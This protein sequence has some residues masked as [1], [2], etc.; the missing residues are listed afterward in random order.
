M[1]AGL[2]GVVV[3]GDVFCDII[4]RGVARLPDWGEEVFGAEP[5]M[6]PGGVANV[7]VGLA[8]LGV[9]THLLA[10]TRAEDTIG[11]VLVTELGRQPGLRVTWLRSA[12]ST[13][14]TVAL[15]HGGERAMVSYVPPADARPLAPLVSWE[16][17]GRVSHVHLG[18]WNEGETLLEDQA[19]ILAAARSRGLT[20]SLDVSWQADEG[21][22][23]RIR[24]LLR[25]VDLVLPN[26]A[27]ACW[28]TG[29]STVDQAVRRLAELVPTVV[30]KLGG[31][32]AIAA[33]DG[34]VERVPGHRVPVV[35]TTGAGDAF[36]AGFLHGFVR[37]WSLGRCLQLANVCGAI[38]V[39]RIGS[40]TS[41]PTRREAFTALERGWALLTH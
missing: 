41:V 14:I 22:G 32:G 20:A 38:S 6:C 12:P 4:V 15:P 34:T 5:V 10:R 8:R 37:R 25:H 28:I 9:P 21:L 40:S 7:A 29:A 31:D 2:G 1:L 16:D 27:E 35:D 30:V 11:S 26:R 3:L 24:A 33:R 39:G 13:A 17:L 18:G 19:A 36:A 23:G